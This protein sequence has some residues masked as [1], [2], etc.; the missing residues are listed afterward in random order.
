MIMLR[1]LFI[2]YYKNKILFDT[3]EEM[4]HTLTVQQAFFFLLIFNAI[5]AFLVGLMAW[6]RRRMPGGVPLI[7]LMASV[8]IWSFFYAY[9]LIETTI[10]AKLFYV[11]FE[12][13][14]IT[15]LPLGTLYVAY[16]HLSQRKFA[17]WRIILPLLILP[18]ISLLLL[19]TNNSHHFFY[20]TVYLK[21]VTGLDHLG[22]I[23]GPWFWIHTVYSYFALGLA[24]FFLARAFWRLPSIYNRQTVMILIA[25]ILPI[26]VNIIR[27]L[28]LF[29][30]P[31]DLTPV[32]FTGSGIILLFGLV[33]FNLF[34]IIPIAAERILTE[35][36]DCLIIVDSSNRILRMNPSA[37]KLLGRRLLNSV[38]E[39]AP[40]LFGSVFEKLF[41]QAVDEFS[42]LEISVPNGAN[43]SFYDCKI[44]Y[45]SRRNKILGKVII[46]RDVTSLK[47]AQIRLARVN[48]ELEKRIYERTEA[49]S[50][51]NEV[52]ETEI[53]KKEMLLKEIHH[54]VKNNLAIIRSLISLQLSEITDKKIQ[55]AFRDLRSRVTS[56]GL[57]HKRLY[58]TEEFKYI[59]YRNYIIDL[60]ST[61]IRTFAENEGEIE[62]EK[63]IEDVDMEI[64]LLIPLGLII[65]ELLTNSLKYARPIDGKTRLH[66]RAFKKED[67]YRIVLSDNGPG[68]PAEVIRYA[69]GNAGFRIIKVL[70][71]QIKGNL[72]F[73]NEE[74]AKA[75]L[76]V[77]LKKI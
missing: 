31:I 42:S 34:N 77:P 46:L 71:K 11:W 39:Y 60:I 45:F 6:I 52:L 20:T 74:G 18:L 14:G 27:I 12:Y 44:S 29:G 35:I 10:D 49:L 73:D 4:V 65:T 25:T 66:M 75:T 56:I 76:T 47:S 51:A 70:I 16:E 9:E 7:I 5:L 53:Q 24:V 3:N 17:D 69:N 23:Y 32:A 50:K 37:E 36:S 26:S 43:I 2:L 21:N 72:F 22:I 19:H 15:I 62:F 33:Y 64:D 68:F 48:E 30:L 28:K 58:E 8:C 63:E 38:G 61:I 59:G 54:R 40:A 55:D 13:I 57:I 41:S 67:Q 1:G